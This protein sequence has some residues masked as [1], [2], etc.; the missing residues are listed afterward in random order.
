M[1][2]RVFEIDKVTLSPS[3]DVRLVA[4][5][6]VASWMPSADTDETV[7]F[8]RTMASDSADDAV[9]PFSTVSV[10]VIVVVDVRV[11]GLVGLRGV[12]ATN[13]SNPTSIATATASAAVGGE[14][15][16]LFHLT[17][18]PFKLI[19]DARLKRLFQFS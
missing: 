18:C 11:T 12:D 9:K 1:V 10:E 15:A 3:P 17:L 2:G 5:I 6:E 19:V 8:P 13:T 7:L 4:L 16:D 14:I